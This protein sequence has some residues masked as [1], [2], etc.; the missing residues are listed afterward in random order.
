MAYNKKNKSKIKKLL[1]VIS[2]QLLVAKRNERGAAALI[3]VLS[4]MAAGLLLIGFFSFTFYSAQK[5]ASNKISAQNDF[6][7]AE[8]GLEDQIYRIKNQKNYT[9][10]NT[11]PVGSGQSNLTIASSGNTKTVTSEAVFGNFIRKLQSIITLNTQEVEF[12]YGVQVGEGGLQAKNGVTIEGNI[13]SNG[14]MVTQSGEGIVKGD[15]YVATAM[16]LDDK[17]E[18][19]NNETI[20][21]EQN[22][23]PNVF[24]IAQSFIPDTTSKLAKIELYLKKNGAPGDITLR[25]L[26]DNS[27]SPSKTVVGSTTLNSSLVTSSY[28]WIDVTFSTLPTLIGG[29]TYWIMLDTQDGS[30]KYWYWGKDQNQGNGNG[31]S[32]YS[33]DWNA[34]TPI[35]NLD[36]G[37]FDF[38]T[39]FGTGIN[40]LDNFTVYGNAYANTITNSEI[41]GDAYYQDIDSSSLNFLNSPTSQKCP[42][43]PPIITT[44]PP[45]AG[46]AYPGSADPAVQNMPVSDG[47]IAQWKNDALTGG[48]YND[49]AHCTP[50]DSTIL[51]PAKLTCDLTISNNKTIYINGPIW[52][53]GDILLDNNVVLILNSSFGSSGAVIIADY[54]TDTTSKGKISVTNGAAICGSAGY[55]TGTNECNPSN[56]SY[57]MMLSTYNGTGK[58]LNINQNIDGGIFYAAYGSAEI[59]N[60]ASVK[61]VIAYK[62]ELENNTTIVYETGLAKANFSSGPGASWQISD[63]KEVE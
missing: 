51:G 43:Y 34:G 53:E 12:H 47:N 6:Y 42:L 38:K 36:I 27:G 45:P 11:L 21:G 31:V 20:F 17:H 37:D 57:I 22:V 5:S 60:N 19:F 40:A 39:W 35:W 4:V 28:G 8:A 50:A 15:A 16:V 49:A 48:T 52:V 41:C 56:G 63:W 9:S 1:S 58:A 46:D 30:N 44:S 25:I 18:V 26:T 54:P 13:Y 61:E 62:L 32:K 2:Y 55:N 23:N 10:S 33:A 14:P 3:T 24:D 29:T 59:E 7:I